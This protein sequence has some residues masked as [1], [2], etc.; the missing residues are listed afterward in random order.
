M[1]ADVDELA[2]VTADA[3]VKVTEV[4]V[5]HEKNMNELRDELAR[6]VERTKM[7]E[8]LLALL[9]DQTNSNADRIVEVIEVLIEAGTVMIGGKDDGSGE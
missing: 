7:H 8:E 5:N 4:L 3:L 1:N 9:T 6:V 2:K